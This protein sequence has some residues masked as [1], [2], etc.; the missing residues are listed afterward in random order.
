PFVASLKELQANIS[1]LTAIF[2]EAGATAE[3][4]AALQE[5]IALKQQQLIDQASANYRSTFYSDAENAAFAR[6][7]ISSTLTPLGY[8][9][10][11][12]VEEYKALVEATDALANPELYGTLMDLSDE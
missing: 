1:Q 10:V 5:L 7:T 3:E 9:H 8:G 2:Q 12:T 4:Y 11:D 6:Q